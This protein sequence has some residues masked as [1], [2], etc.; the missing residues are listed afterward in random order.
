MKK[1]LKPIP[2]FKNED[3]E[4]KFWW[5]HDSTDYVDWSKAVHMSFPNL[6]LTTRPITIRLPA[7]L[8]DRIKIKANKMDI[9]YQTY[10]KQLLFQSI[11]Q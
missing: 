1:K 4:R 5:T 7:G 11:N 10:I 3:E 9:P 2:K 8:I 6:K